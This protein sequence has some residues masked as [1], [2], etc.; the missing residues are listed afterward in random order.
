MSRKNWDAD[1]HYTREVGYAGYGVRPV[2][3]RV[4]VEER[5]LVTALEA[6]DLHSYP[7]FEMLRMWVQPRGRLLSP[8]SGPLKLITRRPCSMASCSSWQR[9]L[10]GLVPGSAKF[11]VLGIKIILATFLRFHE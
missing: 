1:L 6:D 2:K 7:L 5:K 8:D 11:T 4:L 9:G 3:G 10:S